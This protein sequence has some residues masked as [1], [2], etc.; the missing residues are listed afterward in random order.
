MLY[1][2]P[3]EYHDLIIDRRD[4]RPGLA[5]DVRA[6]DLR[7]RRLHRRGGWSES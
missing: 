3:Y 4:G 2:I 7:V 1:P 6:R 5:R